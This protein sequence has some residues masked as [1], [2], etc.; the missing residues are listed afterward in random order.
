MV[1]RGAPGEAPETVVPDLATAVAA[2]DLVAPPGLDFRGYD[3]E[4]AGGAR[5]WGDY[6]TGEIVD[7]ADAVTVEEAEHMMATR[8]WQNTARVHFDGTGREDGRRLVYGGHVISLA[9]ALSFNGLEG[10]QPVLALNGGSHVAPC[11]AGDG[12]TAWS[13]V[14]DRAGVGVPGAGAIRLRLVAAK[15]GTPAGPVRAG[16]GSYAEGVLLDLDI[17]ALMPR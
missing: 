12:V 16:D 4:L 2:E 11:F 1:R 3:M 7:H 10:A 9:R 17:W 14:L 5:R 13:V 8:L 6:E 15:A